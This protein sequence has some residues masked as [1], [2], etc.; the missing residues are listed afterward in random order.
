MGY[1][2]SNFQSDYNDSRSMSGY[3]FIL[4][5]GAVCCKSFKQYTVADSVCK[6]EYNTA[7]DAAKKA[8][9]L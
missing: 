9:W 6:V 8:V 4:N 2:D 1:I 7:S 3:V 5:R